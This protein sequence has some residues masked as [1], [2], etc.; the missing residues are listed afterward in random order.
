MPRAWA[1]D[2]Y[3][4]RQRWQGFPRFQEPDR[5]QQIYYDGTGIYFNTD[6]YAN[7][8]TLNAY[9]GTTVPVD[10]SGFGNTW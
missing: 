6:T 8:A 7:D 4:R 5:T 3:H 2:R 9:A 1:R 10:D